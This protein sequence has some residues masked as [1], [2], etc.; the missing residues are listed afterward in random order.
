M[1]LATAETTE[2][3]DYVVYE[4]DA[5]A[6]DEFGQELS[7]FLS[8]SLESDDT[9]EKDDNVKIPPKI[10][11]KDVKSPS[12]EEEGEPDLE[13]VADES[14]FI[15]EDEDDDDIMAPDHEDEEHEIQMKSFDP[16]EPT[17]STQQ[18]ETVADGKEKSGNSSQDSAEPFGD[19]QRK[20]TN[21]DTAA[22]EDK[23]PE[24]KV[25]EVKVPE[26]KVQEVKVPEVK[27]PEV[28][29]PEGSNSH[30]K[31]ENKKAEDNGESIVQSSSPSYKVEKA[32]S[33]ISSQ[34]TNSSTP[35][36]TTKKANVTD[37]DNSKPEPTK[38]NSTT[39]DVSTPQKNDTGQEN[40]IP[41]PTKND[42]TL[43]EQS[44][45]GAND[46]EKGKPMPDP[47]KIISTSTGSKSSTANQ[48]AR[49]PIP[50]PPW[51][52]PPPPHNDNSKKVVDSLESTPQPTTTSPGTTI[53]PAIKHLVDRQKDLRG[54]DDAVREILQDTPE[55]EA[56]VVNKGHL[57]GLGRHSFKHH[58]DE[59]QVMDSPGQRP[60]YEEP[61]E[62]TWPQQRDHDVMT[63]TDEVILF[64]F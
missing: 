13:A 34:Q 6:P 52:K 19:G 27:V 55:R 41:E 62:E 32:E 14:D 38:L 35:E 33:G 5:E 60:V 47:V 48:N 56:V 3:D 17:K 37:Q 58:V 22:G 9:T 53:N 4:E 44:P 46:N 24:V 63:S 45:A 30:V 23:V 50:R 11:D 8:S 10:D 31:S 42:P 18:N 64:L 61:E 40:S 7:D 15:L 12:K 49:P 26:V 16:K 43:P 1:T 20:G 51:P 39:A 28:K 29:I 21:Q 25:P 57:G 54:F 36:E 59:K 2:S